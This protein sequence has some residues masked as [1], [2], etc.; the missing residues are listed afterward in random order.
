[1]LSI[2]L[3]VALVVSLISFRKTARA[4]QQEKTFASNLS[5]ELKTPLTVIRG[6][7]ELLPA[8]EI[9]EKIVSHCHR[10][11]Q[12]MKTVLRLHSK[13][14]FQPCPIET[15]LEACKTQIVTGSPTTIIEIEKPPASLIADVDAECFE[16][17]LINI[18][19]N[20][21][22]YSPSPAHLKISL[23]KRL[24]SIVITIQDHGIGIPE[25]DLP[26]IFERFY[27]VNATQ[28]RRLGGAGLGLSLVKSLVDK[29]G[30]TISVQSTLGHGSTFTLT[31]PQNQKIQEAIGRDELAIN[32]HQ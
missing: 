15:L 5:H 27:T 14:C 19:E 16:L 31:I 32:S 24:D 23:E 10:M 8:N 28:T 7:A 29:H 26:H 3:V 25:K 12:V 9:S 4:L 20:G 17:A 6:Y 21:I 2:F 1:M 30:G 22:K 13:P 11:E 18:L